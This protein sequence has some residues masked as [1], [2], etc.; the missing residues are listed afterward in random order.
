M[1]KER[2]YQAIAQRCS[3]RKY[4]ADPLP[5]E[6]VTQ[7]QQSITLYNQEADLHIQLMLNAPEVF[8]G[9]RKS[10][11]LFTGVRHYLALVGK[12]NM[13]HIQEKLGFYGE[14]LVLECTAL[15]LGSCW[16]GA[17]YDQKACACQLADDEQL[18]AVIAIGYTPEEKSLREKA[19]IQVSH[20]HHKKTEMMYTVDS[21][22]PM[23]FFT[24]MEA[25][26]QAPSA[27]DA[28]PVKIHYRQGKIIAEMVDL[29][30][31][32]GMDLG[33]AKAHFWLAAEPGS[34]LWGSPAEFQISPH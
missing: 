4:F 7:L 9:L 15:G 21:Q 28:Q 3:R 17:T 16:I 23:W 29:S 5:K 2:L 11:G 27:M 13:P 10:Y 24:A 20:R 22:P 12:K 25:V 18:F 26:Q 6:T 19:I 33:I 32:H 1:K 30:G 34:W 31:Y 14:L 8:Q